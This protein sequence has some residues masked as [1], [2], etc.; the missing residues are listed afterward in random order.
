VA[1]SAGEN[2]GAVSETLPSET[3]L[4]AAFESLGRRFFPGR[5]FAFLVQW[6]RRMTRSAG[7][8]Y[9]RLRV[10]RLSWRYHEVFPGEVENTL[11]H[12]LIHAS[13]IAGHGDEFRREAARLGCGLH[14]RPLPRRPLRWLYA[15]PVCG[16]EV[17]TRR[18]VDFSCGRCSKR[19]DPRYRL[20]LRGELGRAR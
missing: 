17:R 14:A 5:S 4:S 12:E 8:C 2:P 18:R 3:E 11:K 13:G 19:W 15:C 9:H 1:K 16:E 10:V 6:S 20:V 7:L